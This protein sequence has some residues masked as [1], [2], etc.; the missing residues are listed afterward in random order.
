ML[1]PIFYELAELSGNHCNKY[2]SDQNHASYA[3]SFKQID[4]RYRYLL[5]I[6]FIN[7]TYSTAWEDLT[8]P[9]DFTLEAVFEKMKTAEAQEFI[10]FHLGD[11]RNQW[12]IPF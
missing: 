4:K 7:R 11:F 10:L 6:D 5:R 1:P 3:F 8:K 9:Y 2:Y 12:K